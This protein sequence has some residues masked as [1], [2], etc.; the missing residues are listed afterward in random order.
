MCSE[1]KNVTV[2]SRCENQDQGGQSNPAWTEQPA[3]PHHF[4]KNG[5]K[6]NSQ[7]AQ[8]GFLSDRQGIRF[9]EENSH[10]NCDLG[11]SRWDDLR[12]DGPLGWLIWAC[13]RSG[14]SF[15]SSPDCSAVC[16]NRRIIL[17]QLQG[18]NLLWTGKTLQ[19]LNHSEKKTFCIW[20]M[21]I[22]LWISLSISSS[23]LSCGSKC[24]S[25]FVRHISACLRME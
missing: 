4:T 1:L 15:L 24:W 19:A 18:H 12:V 8:L 2:N 11:W 3:G 14:G 10:S 25:V 22:C 17:Q 6:V 7:T 23:C 20:L 21:S 5:W 16:P 9:S 13:Q